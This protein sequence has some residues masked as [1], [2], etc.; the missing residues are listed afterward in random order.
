ML[1]H[2]LILCFRNFRRS[3]SSFVI[4]LVGL[5]SGITCS[6]LLYLWINDELTF[7]KFHHQGDRLFQIM[8]HQ[9]LNGNI[10]T[11][12]NTGEFLAN[13][14]VSEIPEVE[15]AVVTTPENFFPPFA[16][17]SAEK[18]I[19]GTG[20]FADKDF[21]GIFSFELLQGKMGQALMDK[22]SIVI[23]ERL[24]KTLFTS[25]E[26]S[27]GKTIQWEAMNIRREVNVSGV[28]KDLPNNSSQR[29]DFVLAFDAFRDIMGM[30]RQ[31]LDWDNE[32]PFQTYFILH[33]DVDV[34]TFNRKLNNMLSS[35]A[36]NARYRQLFAKAYSDQYLYGH[37]EN[38]KQSGGRIQYVILIS[39]VAGFIL[40]IACIN[41]INLSTA[42]AIVKGKETGIKKAIGA[43][44]KTLIAQFLTES[45]VITIVAIVFS[46]ALVAILL[47]EF[48]TI[49][50][51]EI[52]LRLDLRTSISL[53]AITVFTS[54]LAG[55]YPSLYLSGFSP[56]RTLKG[57]F[58]ASRGANLSRKGLTIFQFCF[59]IVFIAAVIITQAQLDYIQTKNLG[60]NKDNVIYFDAEGKVSQNIQTF[61]SEIRRIDGVVASSSM[62]G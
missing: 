20:K 15:R 44:R 11:D 47:P 6:L 41:F 26:N 50:G 51:K 60:Y 14:L 38:G 54:M 29:F 40:F 43:Q 9:N 49:T 21:F 42:K 5:T 27:I 25:A 30:N 33:D 22:N 55:A 52:E 62:L 48:N 53:L 36:T 57:E 46:I 37:Y 2:Y 16:L 56:A 13:T 10:Q 4:N 39:I 7:D 18:L 17:R 58:T 1:R 23:S 35:K 32:G 3:P 61:L 31:Q 19:K 8:E 45:T 28:F 24:A 59:S 12:G 34:T